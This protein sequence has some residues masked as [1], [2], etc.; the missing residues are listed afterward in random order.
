M[1]EKCIFDDEIEC[2][3]QERIEANL[4]EIVQ[5][6]CPICWKLKLMYARTPAEV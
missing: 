2:P 1:P 5:L 4:K 6:A 3:V